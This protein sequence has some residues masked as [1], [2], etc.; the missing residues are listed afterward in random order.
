MAFEPFGYGNQWYDG[1]GS[2]GLQSKKFAVVL[3]VVIM[4]AIIWEY[5]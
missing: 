1:I 2:R 3:L 4:L 5:S